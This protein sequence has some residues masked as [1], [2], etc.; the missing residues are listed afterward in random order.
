MQLETNQRDDY[1]LTM[2]RRAILKTKLSTIH[3]VIVHGL[4]TGVRRSASSIC[5]HIGMI[6]LAFK[7]GVVE[8]PAEPMA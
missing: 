4:S 8:M 7:S 5:E 3:Q 6:C 1:P 2:C